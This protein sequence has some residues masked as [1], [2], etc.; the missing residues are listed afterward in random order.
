MLQKLKTSTLLSKIGTISSYLLFISTV[1]FILTVFSSTKGFT[2]P[3]YLPEASKRIYYLSLFSY[4]FMGPY[5]LGLTIL[6]ELLRLILK[7]KKWKP[8]LNLNSWKVGLVTFL[9]I[10]IF[11]IFVSSSCRNWWSCNNICKL[12]LYP[13]LHPT[14]TYPNLIPMR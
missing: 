2:P 7:A 11:S 14:P 13:I 3:Y 6:A 1:T 12:Y 5:F 9:I 8:P 4:L 10:L